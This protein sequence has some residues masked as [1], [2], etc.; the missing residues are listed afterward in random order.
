MTELEELKEE[1]DYIQTR[2]DNLRTGFNGG[3][4]DKATLEYKRL[5]LDQEHN[6]SEYIH[7][8]N[9]RIS[10]LANYTAPN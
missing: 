7:T 5:L 10:L 3:R 1:L 8:L 2:R 4:W 9:M 6:M